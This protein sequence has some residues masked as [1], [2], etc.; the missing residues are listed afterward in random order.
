MTKEEFIEGWD[1]FIYGIGKNP[2]SDSLKNMAKV[3][4]QSIFKDKDGAKFKKACITLAKDGVEY[5]SPVRNLLG[6]MGEL[7]R[8]Y[9]E[10][11]DWDKVVGMPREMRKILDGL[12]GK[13]DINRVI[14][15]EDEDDDLPF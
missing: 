13:M 10:D 14:K 12:K 5:F 11:K 3:L 1:I 8:E 4:F 6:E 9:K 15:E 2:T 7:S